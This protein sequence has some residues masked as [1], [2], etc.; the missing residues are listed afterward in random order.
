[1]PVDYVRLRELFILLCDLPEHDRVAQIEQHCADEPELRTELERLLRKDESTIGILPDSDPSAGIEIHLNDVHGHT[2][3]DRIGSYEIQRLLGEGGMG[4]VYLARQ[5]NPQRP[6]AVKIVR[7]GLLSRDLRRRFEFEASVLALLKHP[8]IAQIYEAGMHDDGGS[9]QPYFAMEYVDGPPLMQYVAER[10]ASIPERLEL[11][12][13]I[14]DAAHHA[15]QKGVIHR[16]L[17][18]GNVLVVEQS[19]DVGKATPIH[20]VQPKILDFGVARATDADLQ[21]TTLQTKAGQLIGTLPYMSPEQVEGHTDRLDI[22][23]DVYSLG[24]MLY[25]LLVGQRPYEIGQSS[26]VSASRLIL[27]SFPTPLSSINRVFRGDLNTI[28]MKAL[29]KDPQYRYQSASELAGDIRRFLNH[30]PILAR[31]ATMLYQLSRFARRHRTLV[32]AAVCIVLLAI[33][34]IASVFWQ[35]S[36]TKAEA[37]TRQEVAGF[38]REVLTSVDPAKTAGEPLTVRVMLDDAAIKLDTQFKR[39]PLVRG[40]LHDAIGSTYYLL[41]AFHEAERHLRLAV[42]DFE[43]A[44]GARSDSTLRAMAALGLTMSQLDRLDEARAY[45]EEA[46]ARVADHDSETARRLRTNLAIVFDELGLDEEAEQ[47]YGESYARAVRTLGVDDPT[48]LQV[49]NNL[50]KSLMDHRKF[51]QALPLFVDGVQRCRAVNGDDHPDTIMMLANLSTLYNNMGQVALA[52][53]LAQE[54]AERSLRVLGPTHLGTLRR[55]HALIVIE[56]RLGQIEMARS[57]AYELLATCDRL[58]GGH[59]RETIS[60]LE[61]VAMIVGL[62]GSLESAEQLALERYGQLEAA[63]GAGHRLTG[64]VAHLLQNIYDEWGKLE[65]QTYWRERVEASAFNPWESRQ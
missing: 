30:E 46:Y 41:G 35:A 28:T 32:A 39:A 63:L 5:H 55:Q 57:H 43:S 51:D 40:E 33:V 45:L 42:R 62:G 24:V 1:M 11:F 6:V 17:K 60:A 53:P 38:L 52:S 29:E 20:S 56:F 15:H 47:L 34:G 12:A 21:V 4:I 58:L 14:C 13:M 25:E 48:T 59:H 7:G 49:Q 9:G 65:E 19:R 37:Q 10:N 36:L 31:P 27:E 16:D 8:G 18:P 2:M 26:V 54:A 3:P 22:R 23:S 61:T 44:S 50:A 64:R